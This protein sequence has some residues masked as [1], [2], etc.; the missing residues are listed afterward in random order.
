MWPN[1]PPEE[2]VPVNNS[3]RSTMPMPMPCDSRMAMKSFAVAFR[4]MPTQRQ[5]DHVA[6]VFHGHR[7]AGR[8]L[9]YLVRKGMSVSGVIGDHSKVR[10]PELVMPW[11]ASTMRMTGPSAAAWSFINCCHDDPSVCAISASRGSVS[12]GRRSDRSPTA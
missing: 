1:S 2:C 4:I 9:Q 6:V 10:E 8:I 11:I 12:V 5:R 7:N 3:P